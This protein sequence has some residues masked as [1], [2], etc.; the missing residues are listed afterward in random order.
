M[1]LTCCLA[2]SR[3]MCRFPILVSTPLPLLTPLL[4]VSFAIFQDA[5]LQVS[6]DRSSLQLTDEET[7]FQRGEMNLFKGH[8][9]RK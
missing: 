8:I 7:E 3:A 5:S 2:H 1:A 4:S 6:F 9:P